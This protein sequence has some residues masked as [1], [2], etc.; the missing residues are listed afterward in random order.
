[1]KRAVAVIPARNE[2]DRLP[3]ALASLRREGLAALVVANGCTDA[4]AELARAEGAA[5][6]ETPALAGGVGAARAIGL[7]AALDREARIL[8]TTDADCML[9]PGSVATA[10]RAL[11]YADVV[12]GR[13]VPDA[14]EFASLPEPVQRHGAA[15]DRCDCLRALIA[16]ILAKRPWDPFPAHGQSPGALIAWHASAYRA[17]GGI[18]PVSCHEDRRMAA[19][20]I[21]HGL[22]VARPW[23]AVV[24]ASCRLR[25][26][27]PGGMADTIAER[28]LAGARLTDE[29]VTLER[30]CA[31]LER[32]LA[33][34]MPRASWPNLPNLS[35]KGDDDV[36]SFQQ[37][38]V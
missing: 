38:S 14:T 2:A 16:A 31:S 4:T 7:E 11:D 13:V 19:A 3:I 10:L 21:G 26:R 28:S 6:I 24:V 22:R 30:E 32:R 15:E 20:L 17:V 9:A 33:E 34:L 36:P 29:A 27:A 5:V 8:F 1:M 25:G 18:N 23:D 12:F 37:A 35:P